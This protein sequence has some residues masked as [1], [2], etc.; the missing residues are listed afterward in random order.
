MPVLYFVFGCVATIIIITI[1]LIV[2]YSGLKKKQKGKTK[3]IRGYLDMI[4]DLTET[5]RSSVESIRKSFLPAVEEIRKKL[6]IKRAELAELLFSDS[7]DRSKINT[8]AGEILNHQ[9]ELEKEVI[10]HILEEKELLSPLQQRRF[11]EIIV[12][13]FSSGGLGVHDVKGRKTQ[14]T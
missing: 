5:Q 4:P 1:I 12:D 14:A 9:S 13:Q 10:D 11:Y 2:V 7:I 6:C 8:V 3:N